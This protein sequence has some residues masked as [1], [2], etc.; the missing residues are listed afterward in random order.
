MLT[1]ITGRHLLELLRDGLED[2]PVR[3]RL[4]GR[5]H[6]RLQRV[7]ERVHV[8]G[9]EIVLFVPAGGRQDDVG[10]DR[11]RGHPE[12]D[13]DQQVELALRRLV[14]PDGFLRHHAAFLA[15]VLAHHAVIG[16][17]EV[18]EEILV[19]LARR[20]EQVRAPD[21]QVARPVFRGVRIL[22]G[23]FQIAGFQLFGDVVLDL[24]AGLLRR[25]RDL[26]RVGLELRGGREPAHPL[27]PDV[28]VDQRNV[29]VAFGCR[30]RQDFTGA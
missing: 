6:R 29:P 25:L 8:R 3:F 28:V 27:G 9:V 13:A 12:V 11:R 17:Q 2:F 19:S 24:L 30:R 15:Q 4:V 20:P 1:Q 10:I 16:T 14:M 26:Q 23:H 18:L 21:E 22:A 5:V 7:D